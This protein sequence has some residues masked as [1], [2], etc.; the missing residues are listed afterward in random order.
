MLDRSPRSLDTGLIAVVV[1]HDARE[2]QVASLAAGL[3]ACALIA[4]TAA[5]A[6]FKKGFTTGDGKSL[7]ALGKEAAAQAMEEKEI[8]QEQIVK[9]KRG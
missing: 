5:V 8:G 1:D 2:L 6:E 9:Q 3:A 7:G 4:L